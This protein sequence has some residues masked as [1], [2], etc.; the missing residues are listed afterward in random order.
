VNGPL[1]EMYLVDDWMA[2]HP[3]I[4]AQLRSGIDVAEIGPG[5]GQAMRLLATAFPASRFTGCDLDPL[6]VERAN[7]AAA[8]AGL[9][10]LRFEIRDGAALPAASTD[11]VLVFD[12]FHHFTAPDAILEGIRRALREGGSL[13]VAEPTLA[14][15]PT[16]DAADG[17][18]I[19]VYGS[20]L[21]YCYQ[22]S[23]TAGNAGL[24]ATWGPRGLVPLLEARGFRVT[25]TNAAKGGY[26]L[27]RAVPNR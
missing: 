16:A 13:L 3:E 7:A 5:G 8:E 21:L 25:T 4:E 10:N 11:L 18:A 22:E 1:Y 2:G 15:D 12:V 6:Q 9:P 17:F 27:V 20:N 14:G 26:D 19:I 24:G 23:K